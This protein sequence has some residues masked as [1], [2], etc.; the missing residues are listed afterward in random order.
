MARSGGG[1]R[2]SKR[3]Q[4]GFGREGQRREALVVVVLSVGGGGRG[5]R[6]TASSGVMDG[7]KRGKGLGLLAEREG[8][9]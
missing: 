3:G 8:K 4:P 7:F 1:F 6:W 5:G 2:V 9:V